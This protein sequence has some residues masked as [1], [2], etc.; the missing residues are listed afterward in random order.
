MQ[1]VQA[2]LPCRIGL[3]LNL[4]LYVPGERV[5]KMEKFAGGFAILV[6]GFW[7]GGMWAIGYIAAPVL[8]QT[9]TD[10]SQAGMLA[11]RLFA[12]TAWVG[13]GC[14]VYLLGFVWFKYRALVWRRPVFWLIM[15]MLA[16]VLLGHFGIQ[17]LLFD[18]KQQALPQYVMESAYAGQFGLWHGI[19]SLLYLVESV[20]GAVLLLK[21]HAQLN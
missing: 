9:L 6:A 20:C 5:M 17:P 3:K 1:I 13:M 4:V 21:M 18:L 19:S 7:V 8:F 11:G 14:A 12:V 16:I 2:Y 15:A 10:K